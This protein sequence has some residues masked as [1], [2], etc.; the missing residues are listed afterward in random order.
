MAGPAGG[1]DGA[2]YRAVGGV[3]GAAAA[4]QSAARPGS[5]LVGAATRAPRRDFEWGPSLDVP[6][7]P[8]PSCWPPLRRTA[9]GRPVAESGRR[10]LA[11]KA[12]LVGRDTELAVLTEAVRATVSGRGGVCGGRR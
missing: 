4:L 6:L 3:V 9:A 11:A 2:G 12:P 8:E 10:R 1:G 7:S 5:V